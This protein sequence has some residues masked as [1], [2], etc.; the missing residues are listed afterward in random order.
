M[1]NS[2]PSRIHNSMNLIDIDTNYSSKLPSIHMPY[3]PSNHE[4][5]SSGGDHDHDSLHLKNFPNLSESYGASA[6][7]VQA[8]NV[9]SS[10]NPSDDA[11]KAYDNVVFDILKG[12]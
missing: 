12:M 6:S 3:T 7:S 5:N 4:A 11:N 9:L 2:Q 10:Y 1:T 8:A